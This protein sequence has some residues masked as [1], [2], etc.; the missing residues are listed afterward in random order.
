MRPVKPRNRCRL[1]SS[2]LLLVALNTPAWALAPAAQNDAVR[3]ENPYFD[4]VDIVEETATYEWS[5]DVV[6]NTDQEL[7]LRIILDVLDDDDKAINRDEQ[8]NP[9]D[10]KIIT[11]Q[12]GQKVAV[13]GQ[14]AMSYDRAAE[15][16]TFRHRWE[17]I[18]GEP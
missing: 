10:L 2:V 16:V 18:R 3:L 11:I 12:P 6:N 9:L 14:G 5:V 7:R 1:W 17:I 4:W 15:V 13:K 8:G